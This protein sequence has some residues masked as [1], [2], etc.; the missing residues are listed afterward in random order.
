MNATRATIVN[1][2]SMKSSEIEIRS[3]GRSKFVLTSEVLIPRSRSDVFSFFSDAHNLEKITPDFLNFK[4]LTPA[5][6]EMRVGAKIDYQIRLHGIP[7]R[8][9]TNICLWQPEERFADQQI[10]GPYRSW[11][12]EHI[13]EDEYCDEH[14]PSTRMTDVVHY[15]VWLGR[16][17]EPL[18]VRKDLLRI[19]EYRQ[20]RVSELFGAQ[21]EQPVSA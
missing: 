1:G 12:H 18:F 20:Q 3:L 10:R 5:P 6:I 13:F 14:G 9:R 17:I 8:W 19:F 16:L 4:I 11:H 15:S 7:L 2:E 21:K